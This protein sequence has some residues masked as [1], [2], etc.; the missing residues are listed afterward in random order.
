MS[1]VGNLPIKLPQGVSLHKVGSEVVVKGPLGELRINIPT[2]IEVDLK[3]E[4]V[5]VSRK[6]E[7]KQTKAL[8]GTIRAH[9][10]N[11]V[12]GVSKGWS[13][14]LELVGTGYRAEVSGDKLKLS[15]GYSHP[16]E[17]IAPKGISFKVEKSDITV[18]GCDKD[19]VGQVAATIRSKR[20]PE[21]YK[22]KGIKYKGEV[23]RRKAGKAAKAAS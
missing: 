2:G 8:H 7:L 20:K 21:P 10:S 22:G 6:N 14:T 3:N 19:L 15:V 5:V 1:R 11:M 9:V 23:I 12:I 4:E 13:K 18:S 17:I 16:I